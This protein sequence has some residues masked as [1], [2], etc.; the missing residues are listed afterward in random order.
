MGRFSATVSIEE[1]KAKA[2]NAKTTKS[3]CQWLCVY[4]SWTKLRN[5]QQENQRLEPSRLDKILQL[6]Y[7]KVKRK[8]GTDYEPSSFAN[9][10][11]ALDHHLREGYMYFLLTSRHS[12]NSRNV[13]KGKAR[14]L[15]EQGKGK[16][17]NKSCSL[18]SFTK[19]MILTLIFQEF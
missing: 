8:G 19:Y 5:N 16:C 9:M 17:P 1:L 18:Q 10:Q 3:T 15:G 4:L 14:L 6:F 13:L 2:K 7:A 12:L 11:A